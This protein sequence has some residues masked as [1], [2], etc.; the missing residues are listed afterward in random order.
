ML[1]DSIL[2]QLVFS[3]MLVGLSYFMHLKN[4]P[5]REEPGEFSLF[6]FFVLFLCVNC[7]RTHCSLGERIIIRFGCL[8]DKQTFYYIV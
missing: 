8:Y 4:Q 2:T 1:T 5:K 3:F 7:I 6:K